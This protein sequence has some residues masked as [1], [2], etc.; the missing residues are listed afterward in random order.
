MRSL[1]ERLQA[2]E[3]Q[4]ARLA[5]TETRLKLAEKRARTHR[6]IQTG[7]LVEKAGLTAIPSDALYG[8]LL[9][10]RRGAGDGKQLDLWTAAGAEA[11]VSEDRA[12]DDSR[13]PIVMTFRIDPPKDAVIALKAGGFRFNKVLR[14][15]EGFALLEEAEL[16]AEAYGGEAH[17]VASG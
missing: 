14:H 3:Q 1:A 17:K 16:L 5:D 15:W 4:K 11:R 10:L 13:E 6:L 12:N 9:S 7:T 8:A 2:Y